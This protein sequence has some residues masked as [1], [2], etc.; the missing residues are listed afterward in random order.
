MP[1]ASSLVYA[2][3]ALVFISYGQ[4]AL[5]KAGEQ[6]PAFDIGLVWYGSAVLASLALTLAQGRI[7]RD[8]Q[9]LAAHPRH[10]ALM[11]FFGVGEGLLWFFSLL[12]LGLSNM[13][14]MG[15]IGM[16]IVFL[17]GLFVL[18]ERYERYHMFWMTVSIV[19]G[20]LFA[21]GADVSQNLY[22]YVLAFFLAF[23]GA[24]L[25]IT[26]KHSADRINSLTLHMV[27]AFL[28]WLAI[29][30]LYV[31]FH[32][33]LI[34][35]FSLPPAF[36]LLAASGGIT[37]AVIGQYTRMK[38]LEN[39][40]KLATVTMVM[41]TGPVIV[42]LCGI[43]IMDEPGN[44]WKYAAAVLMFTALFALALPRKDKTDA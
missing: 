18:K 28:I 20:A 27:R 16:I 1:L 3:I 7:G 9:R 41:N 42:F 38:A 25:F 33:S 22:G 32:H 2:I 31:A 34:P 44:P 36:M 35:H 23:F 8:L 24:G 30:A 14:I 4:V 11:L 29:Y 21:L 43:F 6:G 39:G 5:G 13:A 10:S 12:A 37:N 26:K 15:R 17:Y 19:A 40:G